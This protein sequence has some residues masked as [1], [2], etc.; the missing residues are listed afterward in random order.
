M[1]D[2]MLPLQLPS[3]VLGFDESRKT[4]RLAKIAKKARWHVNLTKVYMP[5]CFLLLV[6]DACAGAAQIVVLGQAA[7]DS[8]SH[9]LGIGFSI[10]SVSPHF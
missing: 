9:L 1:P 7:I 3:L 10:H 8:C 4:L 2:K 6:L 5:S